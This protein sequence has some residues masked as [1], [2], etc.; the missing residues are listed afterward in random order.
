MEVTSIE[1]VFFRKKMYEEIEKLPHIKD[2]GW[3]PEAKDFE[4]VKKKVICDIA[5]QI[6]E[7]Q[8]KPK[9]NDMSIW[10]EAEQIWN[11]IRFAWSE[12]PLG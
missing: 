5:Y 10:L 1:I 7:K 9:N 2:N 6:W 8:G 4:S 3:A 11:L 12:G